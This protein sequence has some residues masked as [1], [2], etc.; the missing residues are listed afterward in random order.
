LKWKKNF[1]E[2]DTFAFSKG[3]N[4]HDFPRYCL[5]VIVRGDSNING[6]AVKTD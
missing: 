6:A 4:R 1:S 5:A 2:N 3:F